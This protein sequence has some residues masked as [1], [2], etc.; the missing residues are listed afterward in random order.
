MT[1]HYNVQ[2]T[3]FKFLLFNRKKNIVLINIFDQCVIMSKKQMH[4]HKIRIKSLK[5]YK[6]GQWFVEATM[7]PSCPEYSGQDGDRHPE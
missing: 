5:I 1:W 6:G 4:C 7:L 2:S 3:I